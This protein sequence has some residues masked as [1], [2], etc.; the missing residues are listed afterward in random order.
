M[1][2]TLRLNPR[3]PTLLLRNL[4]VPALRPTN[5][6]PRHP[7]VPKGRPTRI[8]K[9][10]RKHESPWTRRARSISKPR[11]GTFASLLRSRCSLSR[12]I[13]SMNDS[14]RSSSSESYLPVR[15]RHRTRPRGVSSTPHSLGRGTCPSPGHRG[16]CYH[17]A[18][19]PS[20]EEAGI[21]TWECL[22]A[23]QTVV[24]RAPDA[25]FR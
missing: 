19:N 10:R 2:K 15:P 18:R 8:P 12:R 9:S 23:L 1:V 20:L 22:V 7:H 4:S 14:S 5:P 3:Q 16:R 6:R 24:M 13:F 11:A 21:I 25:W 17:V